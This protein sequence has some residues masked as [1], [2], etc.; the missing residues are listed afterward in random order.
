[1]ENCLRDDLKPIEQAHAFRALIDRR[2]WSYRQL[3][4]TLHIA[5][6]SVARS[7]AL[8]ELPA[9]VQEQVTAGTLAPSVAYEVSRLDDADA[10]RD[11]AARIVAEGL[12]RS[13]A[14]EVVRK[15]AKSPTGAKGRG[16]KPRKVT[17]RTFRA[18]G[19]KATAECPR[20]IDLAGLLAFLEAWSAA[21]RAESQ[22]EAGM[23]GQ[24]E[25]A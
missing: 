20:G 15:A 5:P 11:V 6:A 4:D 18:S 24:G 7:L 17:A 12:N 25:A 14:A 19:Y 21:V 13:E 22:G 2:G 8:L 3:A 9:E 23:R 16:A 1:V 10:R